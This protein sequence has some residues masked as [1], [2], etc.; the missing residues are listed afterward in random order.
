[1]YVS[2]KSISKINSYLLKNKN[3][4]VEKTL[5]EMFQKNYLF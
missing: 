5:K 2:L 4:F 1:M 3:L